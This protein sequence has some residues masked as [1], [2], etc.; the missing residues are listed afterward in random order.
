MTKHE[1]T[2]TPAARYRGPVG[3]VRLIAET[4]NEAMRLR[5]EA[6]KRYPRSFTVE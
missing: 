6:M 2:H 5:N 1:A 3:F 4:V